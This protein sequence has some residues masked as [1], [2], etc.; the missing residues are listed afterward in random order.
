MRSRKINNI[1]THIDTKTDSLLEVNTKNCCSKQLP[2]VE[3]IVEV[4]SIAYCLQLNRSKG[5]A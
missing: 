3:K 4:V 5:T 1:G 2:E